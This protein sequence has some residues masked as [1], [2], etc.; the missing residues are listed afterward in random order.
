MDESAADAPDAERPPAADVL[1]VLHRP[2][3]REVPAVA[4]GPLAWVTG[5][6]TRAAVEALLV[7]SLRDLLARCS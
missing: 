2:A 1:D 4:I 3:V 7:D 5:R 6:A